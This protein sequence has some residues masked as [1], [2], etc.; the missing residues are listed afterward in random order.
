MMMLRVTLAQ[1]NPVAGDLA[2]N[3]ALVTA[4]IG[5]ATRVGADLLLTPEMAIT[6]Y[7]VEDLLGE[8][9]FLDDVEHAVNRVAACV[10]DGL[11]A[12]IGAPVRTGFLPEAGGGK[13]IPR[14]RL[15][16]TDRVVRNAALLATGGRV[17][18]AHTKALLPT[19][20]VFDDSRWTLPGRIGQDLFRVGGVTVAV[21]VCED[22]WAD[23]VADAAAGAG[24]QVL[25]TINASPYYLGK[26]HARLAL[27]RAL[28]ARTGLT[29]AYVNMVGGQDEVVFDGGS[30]VVDPDGTVLLQAPLFRDG[31]FTVDIPVH[32][33]PTSTGAL[34]LGSSSSDRPALNPARATW[35]GWQEEMYTAIVSGL[36]DYVNRNGFT[37]VILGLSGGLDS[38]L[39]AVVAVDALGPDR[40]WG[41]TMPGPYSSPGSVSDA[42]ALATNLGIRCD[43][44]SIRA[45][46]EAELAL[47]GPMLSGPG[48]GVA[49][50]N[51][52][53]RLRA[54]HLMTLANAAGNT[55]MVNTGNR[56]ESAV[57]FFTLGGDSSGG[58]APLRDVA[59]TVAYDL[60]RW[61]N[62]HALTVGQ[63][64]PIPVATLTKPPSAELAPDQVDTNTL[65]PY[66]VLDEILVGYIEDMEGPDEIT[67]RLVDRFNMATVDA[68]R[69]VLQVMG[70]IDRAEHKRRQVAPGIKLTR[71]QVGGRDRRVPITNLRVH[72]FAKGRVTSP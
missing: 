38:A 72:H 35:P 2:G 16:A 45:T 48:A 20:S 27:L 17:V 34:E 44:L 52:Q 50:E 23:E 41:V 18:A 70:M 5:A 56:S 32:E 42:Y 39:A 61:R 11:V 3:T 59:K 25:L 63:V 37:Q 28:A 36:G 33:H 4:A 22:I 12:V 13:A 71:R 14:H 43:T 57:G 31:V 62:E 67:A 8:R 24:A 68:E 54:L 69:V 65:P 6:G 7:P 51:I 21:A 60:A 40:V 58:F 9:A 66:E 55:M 64:A 29:V 10:P 15:D 53:A 46:F 49:T 26:P 1:L 30:L 19:N 47:L